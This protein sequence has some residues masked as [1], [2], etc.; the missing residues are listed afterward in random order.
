[1]VNLIAIYN[2]SKDPKELLDKLQ[3]IKLVPTENKC[4]NCS[5]EMALCPD[6]SRPE[7]GV[8]RCRAKYKQYEKAPYKQCDTRNSVRNGIIFEKVEGF[9]GGSNWT[10]FQVLF[11]SVFIIT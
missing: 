10:M 8:W 11:S 4:P 1:M 3:K 5:N 7:K 6:D 9:G 2:V